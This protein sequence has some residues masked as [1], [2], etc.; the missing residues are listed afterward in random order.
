METI[1]WQAL[2][3]DNNQHLVVNNLTIQDAQ[4]MHVSFFKCVHVNASNL[5]VTAP[6]DSPNTNGI[7]VTH[8]Q[9]ILIANSTI[10]TGI[11][12]SFKLTNP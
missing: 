5:V 10:G 6:G 9:H 7:H 3:F 12:L 4:Q 2:T 11:S 8:T 1:V